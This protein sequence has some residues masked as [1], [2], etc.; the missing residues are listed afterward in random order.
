MDDYAYRCPVTEQTKLSRIDTGVLS[1]PLIT[2]EG[3]TKAPSS[4][5]SVTV[6]RN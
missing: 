3:M 5:K 2:H 4:V 6:A 1:C